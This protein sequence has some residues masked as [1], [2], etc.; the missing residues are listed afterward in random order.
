MK[1]LLLGRE[2]R[3]VLE[4]YTDGPVPEGY[5]RVRCDYGA[6]KHGTE[7][8]GTGKDPFA[9]CYYDEETH[10]FRKRE[11]ELWLMMCKTA[12]IKP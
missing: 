10:I 11:K 1:Q 2:G 4:E 8:H 7:W 12:P 5:V 3:P 6:P 9:A